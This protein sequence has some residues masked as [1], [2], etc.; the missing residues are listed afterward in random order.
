M[1][2]EEKPK[3]SVESV[4]RFIKGEG[5]GSVNDLLL[6]SDPTGATWMKD[7]DE[8]MK[9]E[10]QAYEVKE[11]AKF[12]IAERRHREM[13]AATMLAGR[14]FQP[15]THAGLYDVVTAIQAMDRERYPDERI[16]EKDFA[17]TKEKP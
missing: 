2:D 11:R 3:E 15:N 8:R 17:P 12:V 7:L 4:L 1:S 9:T 14:E 6:E 16:L 10:H 13:M 5:I